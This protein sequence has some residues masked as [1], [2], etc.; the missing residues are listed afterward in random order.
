M[1]NEYVHSKNGLDMDKLEE[2][3]KIM[4][5][6]ELIPEPCLRFSNKESL[7]KFMKLIKVKQEKINE[8][9][10]D[11][12]PVIIDPYLPPNKAI[13]VDH[14]NKIT[15]IELDEEFEMKEKRSF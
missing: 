10:L 3:R 8:I 14:N 11:S 2:L 15:I 5:Q 9:Q 4:N 7:D 1:V 6:I 12:F 13:L